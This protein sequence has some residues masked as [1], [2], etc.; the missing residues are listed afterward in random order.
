MGIIAANVIN[1]FNK[2]DV[3]IKYERVVAISF[4][5]VQPVGNAFFV[6]IVLFCSSA[7]LCSDGTTNKYCSGNNDWT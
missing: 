4:E 1:I 2:G 6:V 7:H 5:P 3:K